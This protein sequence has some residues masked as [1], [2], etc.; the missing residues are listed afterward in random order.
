MWTDTD[1]LAMVDPWDFGLGLRDSLLVA[2]VGLALLFVNP[3]TQGPAYYAM[4]ALAVLLVGTVALAYVHRRESGVDFADGLAVTGIAVLVALP[5]LVAVDAAAGSL[6][7]D[8]PM[9]EAVAVEPIL[10]VVVL[11]VVVLTVVPASLM[12]ALGTARSLRE[13]IAVGGLLALALALTVTPAIARFGT[14]ATVVLDGIAGIV[15]AVLLGA[16]LYVYGRL[17]T[18][19]DVE[20]SPDGA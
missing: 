17:A 11:G 8:R 5:V 20:R 1:E 2:A 12:F 16:P 4:V 15:T 13:R 6:L 10:F 7:W 19:A 3:S 9:S 18:S 14:D